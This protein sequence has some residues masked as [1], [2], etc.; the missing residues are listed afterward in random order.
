MITKLGMIILLEHDLE[1]AVAFYKL[2]GL[3]PIFHIKKSWAEFAISSV[4]LGL[5]PTSQE[6]RERITGIVLEVDDINTMF[7]ELKDKI[8]F[9]TEPLEKVHGIMASIQDPGGNI[10]DLYQ[11]TP[12]K[13]QKLVKD[14]VKKD[15]EQ[16]GQKG[17]QCG[18]GACNHQKADA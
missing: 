12:H 4:K 3:K 7:H 1:A 6:P 5:C 9:K 13:V 2:L 17:C 14:V 15:Q 18:L 10:I 11:P 8:P 16:E